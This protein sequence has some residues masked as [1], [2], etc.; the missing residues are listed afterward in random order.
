MKKLKDKYYIIIIVL[1][2]FLSVLP[3]FINAYTHYHDSSFHVTVINSIKKMITDNNIS[4]ILPDGLGYGTMLFYPTFIHKI[5]AIFS[6]ITQINTFYSV[7]IIY[8]II[9]LLSGLSMYHLVLKIR[10]NKISALLSSCIYILMPY[11]ISDM[12][13]RGAL[14]E[15]LLFLG[16]PLVFLSIY[17]L[18]KNN[19]KKF[20]LF[21]IIG[22]LIVLQSQII[23][24]IYFSIIFLI[25]L[26][27]NYK[28]L[29]K[30]EKIKSLIIA[31]LLVSIIFC[32][33]LVTLIETNS[34]ADYLVFQENFMS[35][36]KLVNNYIV[37]LSSL[38]D[39]IF[40]SSLNNYDWLN[41]IQGINILVIVL[42]IINIYK[43]IKKKNKNLIFYYFLALISILMMTGLIK[44]DH[45]PNFLLMI[46]FPFRLNVFLCFALA[47]LAG[48]SIKNNSKNLIISFILIG[49]LLI[50][51]IRIMEYYSNN[52]YDIR[53]YLREEYILGNN[54][55]YLPINYDINNYSLNNITPIKDD[56][57]TYQFTYDS[58]EENEVELPRIYYYGYE[59][60]D[61]D[62]R[63][64]P[65]SISDNGLIK[66]TLSKRGNYLLHYTGS[67]LYN[68]TNII[69]K[70]TIVVLLV[71]FIKSKKKRKHSI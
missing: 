16:M 17:Y 28:K 65:L 54:Q 56:V 23:L 10:N 45:M 49:L 68:V 13:I 32:P 38:I 8:F 34:H 33:Y 35:S 60:L 6:T 64:Y 55:E 61:E 19:Y 26:L 15:S 14:N 50:P 47:I 40:N 21:F 67:I 59:L 43:D 5:V 66:T 11:R 20:Y 42:I 29:I 70:T 22:Y 4:L 27:F 18:F 1:L 63:S 9:S 7:S 24:A 52:N 41:I 71:L 44:W 51:T 37:D 36:I 48:I 69:S 58:D 57:P 30:K 46:Q 53:D 25:F 62:N 3:M 12:L 31:T 2:A 39:P